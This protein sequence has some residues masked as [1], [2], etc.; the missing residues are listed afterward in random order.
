M[1]DR[2]FS[3]IALKFLNEPP[4]YIRLFLFVLF[5]KRSLKTNNSFSLSLLLL[6]KKKKR[7]LFIFS[8]I[9][10]SYLLK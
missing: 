7:F 10:I 1:G 4:I 9:C 3:I 6:N 5:F 2:A 8:F